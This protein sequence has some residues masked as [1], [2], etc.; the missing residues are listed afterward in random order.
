M[1]EVYVSKLKEELALRLFKAGAILFAE[2][3][4]ELAEHREDPSAPR[5][6]FK[7]NIRTE[8]IGGPLDS[9]DM[10]LIGEL[11]YITGRNAGIL[12]L[13]KQVALV[14]VPNAGM[15]IAEALTT[16][17]YS[18]LSGGI[19]AGG[20]SRVYLKK[21]YSPTLLSDYTLA[22]EYPTGR[23]TGPSD[24]LIFVDDLIRGAHTKLKALEPLRHTPY[25]KHG[26]FLIQRGPR[27]VET[28][29]KHGIASHC[30]YTE[31]ELFSFYEKHE[32]LSSVQQEMV[33]SYLAEHA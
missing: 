32:L 3:G 27:G 5:S 16:H 22:L 20:V 19:P 25:V 33:W 2:E 8:G 11:L 15:R 30:V 10:E 24:V 4:F 28:L 9:D 29:Q 1:T 23:F 18:G 7:F 21:V 26:L 31:E 6:P 12:P 14:G 13:D 17:I